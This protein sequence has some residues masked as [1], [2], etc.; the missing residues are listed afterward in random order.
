MRFNSKYLNL[1]TIY[2]FFLFLALLNIFFSTD[3]VQGKTF[4]INDIKIS[5]PFEINFDKKE[6]I[7]K[8]FIQA[9]DQLILSIVRTQ[10]QKKLRKIPI[11]MIKGMIEIFSIKKEK[12]IDETYHLNLSVSFNKKKIFNLLQEKNIF[13]SLPIKKDIF[14]IPI[15]IE[16][17]K[18]EILIFSENYLFNNWNKIRKNY[19]LINY[20]L[21]T[22]DL[23][24]LDLIKIKLDN[25]ED[26]DFQEI[27]NKYNLKD[28]II[29]IV[30]KN[31]DRIKILSKINL[32]NNL[33]IKTQN[34]K[35]QNFKS[36]IEIEEF[37]NKIKNVYEN[38]WKTKNQINT[39]LKFPIIVSIDN[40]DNSKISE[41]EKS[42]KELDFL[43][44]FYIYK[45]DN[46]RNIYKIIFNGSP[47]NF[48]KTMN[49]N[50]YNFDT[51]NQIWTLR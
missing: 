9:F 29:M 10:D 39:S 21:P 13:P 44:D 49:K 36:Q 14:F 1:K 7:D 8:G 34:F 22:E 5:T 30:F 26:Y 32:N 20:I 47:E 2:I 23:E 27:I 15:V 24:D 31:T 17:E 51:Q 11:S 25:L 46:K 37:I 19:H 35:S 42:V 12:F 3:K 6:I 38:Y 48:L 16:E 43:Y 4:I 33:N 18:N 50:N 45:F 28:Y 40:N 41:F